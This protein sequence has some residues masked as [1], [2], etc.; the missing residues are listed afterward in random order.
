MLV[1][2]LPE[3]LWIR[4]LKQISQRDFRCRQIEPRGQI[5]INIQHCLD[6]RCFQE[7][8]LCVVHTVKQTS[9][10]LDF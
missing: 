4:V 6:N 8:E 3:K 7:F 1:H 2:K 9:T 10:F 5:T